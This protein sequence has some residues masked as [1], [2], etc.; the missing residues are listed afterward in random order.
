VDEFLEEEL[1]TRQACKNA[2]RAF[3]DQPV[4]PLINSVGVFDQISD[5]SQ[6]SDLPLLE[7]E[8]SDGEFSDESEEFNELIQDNA[9]LPPFS[10]FYTEEFYDDDLGHASPTSTHPESSDDSSESRSPSKPQGYWEKR[11]YH[12]HPDTGRTFLDNY[13]SDEDNILRIEDTDD[14]ECSQEVE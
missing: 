1:Q 2:P 10:P 7:I 8:L 4:W 3:H 6:S 9:D 13:F 5:P 12:G 11:G 14:G